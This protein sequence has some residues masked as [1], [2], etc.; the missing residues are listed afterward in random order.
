MERR[1]KA[2]HRAGRNY[3]TQQRRGIRR[4]RRL[5]ATI[6]L[7]QGTLA[8]RS[9]YTIRQAEQ[10]AL[11]HHRT[12]PQRRQRLTH[13]AARTVQRRHTAE[14]VHI[15][16]HDLQHIHRHRRRHLSAPHLALVSTLVLRQS[17]GQPDCL[18][19]DLRLLTHRT[20]GG[21]TDRVLHLQPLRQRICAKSRTMGPPRVAHLAQRQGDSGT[22]MGT[23]RLRHSAG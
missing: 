13:T 19:M 20:G 14:V 7:P 11:A 3:P 6:P 2:I 16:R 21:S 8:Q 9:S 4:V 17:V 12:V 10:R 1:R 22:R 23:D 15:Q 18:R 5:R